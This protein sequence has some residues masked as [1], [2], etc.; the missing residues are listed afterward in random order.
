M[1]DWTKAAEAAKERRAELGITQDEVVGRMP[2][3]VRIDVE[4]YRRFERHEKKSYRRTTLAL[5]SQA[6]DWPPDTLWN[7]A[8][9]GATPTP[10]PEMDE[11]RERVRRL[12]EVI[13][14]LRAAI[15]AIA[16]LV[17]E[18]D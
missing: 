14:G 5:I 12:E 11:L 8:F 17:E 15:A 7:V 16:P 10:N 6:L 18:D 9:G 2:V 3:D 4:T 13:D 1:P